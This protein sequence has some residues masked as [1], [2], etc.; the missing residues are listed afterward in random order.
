MNKPLIAYYFKFI[1]DNINKNGYFNSI[2]YVKKSL[3]SV[4]FKDYRD[5]NEIISSKTRAR[6]IQ[7]TNYKRHNRR[8]LR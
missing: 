8:I 3:G 6:N 1:E 5:K 2:R 4:Y 7:S